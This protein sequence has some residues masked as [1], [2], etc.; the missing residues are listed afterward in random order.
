MRYLVYFTQFKYMYD[1]ISRICEE[2]KLNDKVIVHFYSGKHNS[3][4]R[5]NF[6]YV[7]KSG[8]VCVNYYDI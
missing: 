7:L 1:C 6:M 8:R 4:V 5:T 3:F 2:R